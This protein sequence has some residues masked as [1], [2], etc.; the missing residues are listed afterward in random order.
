VRR[1][2]FAA[3][4]AGAAVAA[5]WL[6][7]LRLALDGAY[8]LPLER[9]YLL[10][11]QARDLAS[12][13]L[14]PAEDGLLWQAL[15][16]PGAR[17][18]DGAH[19]H[20]W[21]GLLSALV[22]AATAAVTFDLGRR[23]GGSR[24]GA[25]AAAL[26][27]VNGWFL[28]GSLAGTEVGLAALAVVVAADAAVAGSTWLLAAALVALALTVPWGAGA[29]LV[30][31]GVAAVPLVRARRLEP[32]ASL[33]LVAIAALYALL[34][35]GIR[36]LVEPEPAASALREPGLPVAGR[37]AAWL[38]ETSSAASSF[39]VTEPRF[40]VPVV[41]AVLA[42]AGIAL[43]GRAFAALAVSAVALMLLAAGT[44]GW[45]L[46]N[47]RLV[48]PLVP[49]AA[50][51]AVWGLTLLPAPARGTAGIALVVLAA[52][53][54]AGWWGD[55]ADGASQL[56]RVQ[57]PF[58]RETAANMAPGSK[59][60]VDRPGVFSFLA[61]TSLDL[62]GRESPEL[63]EA[64]QAG[65]GAVWESLEQLPVELRPD[66]FA[67]SLDRLTRLGGTGLLGRAFVERR[68]SYDEPL[69]PDTVHVLTV[70]GADWT[71][72]GRADAPPEAR[73]EGQGLDVGD[74]SGERA[75]SYQAS[76]NVEVPNPAADV[77]L[78]THDGVSEGCRRVVRERFDVVTS[79]RNGSLLARLRGGATLD[80]TVDG[81]PAGTL[82]VGSAG[83]AFAYG[84]VQLRVAPGRH[85]VELRSR[86]EAEYVSC[87]YWMVR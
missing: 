69:Q 81:T 26:V 63:R 36:V 8:A 28:Y 25:L 10:L 19:A 86:D 54:L 45:E 33:G 80:V 24:L 12:G 13:T 76:W 44:A 37:V 51:A 18:A 48:A 5:V 68:I 53:P 67:V 2:V 74:L 50:A 35:G 40:L 72:A 11:A 64:A 23:A 21:I 62:S 22:V 66:L 3:G 85:T 83:D 27:L 29:A 38:G 56:S 65:L 87:R 41:L 70:Y 7:G 14:P 78:E 73:V 71:V 6:A 31:A 82:A 32:L 34:Q 77:S 52:L 46:D 59:V 39:L 47:G 49:L 55:A 84:R 60:A 42:G 20:L 57:V 9:P 79:G 30:A 61:G 1:P 43:L 17:L 58:A 15:L 4:V 75:A 16:L